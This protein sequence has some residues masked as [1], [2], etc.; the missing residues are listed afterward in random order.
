MKNDSLPQNRN[1]ARKKPHFNYQEIFEYLP[2]GVFTIDTQWKITSFNKTAEKITDY[3]RQEVIGRHCWEVFRSE[4]CS[5]GCPLS[6]CFETGRLQMDQEVAVTDRRG[7]TKNLIVNVNVLQDKDG[8]VHGGVETFRPPARCDHIPP[9]TAPAF[10][11]IIGKS[12]MMQ[13]IFGMLPDVAASET[14]VLL[15]GESG[16]GKEVLA[17]ALHNRSG[18]SRGPFVAVNCSALAESI[19]ESELFGHEKG[20][21]TGADSLKQ[22]RFEMARGGTLFLDEIGDLKPQIQVKL[23]RVLE[24][25]EFERVG[26]TRSIKLDARIISA[27]NQNLE[28]AMNEKRFRE[29]LYFRLRTVPFY[30]PPLRQRKEDIP[31]LVS[32]FIKIFNTRYNKQVRSVDPKVMRIF[33]N[34]N[35]PGNIRELE[36]ILEYAFVFVKGPVIFE[37]HLPEIKTAEKVQPPPAENRFS[38]GRSRDKDTILQ[39]LSDAGG[40]RQGAAELLGI[41]RTSL[42]RRMKEFGLA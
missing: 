32:H 16:T 26:G 3:R 11:G 17:R 25:R 1:T 20:A 8:N 33:M 42:W 19:L 21:F 31:P 18:R 6:I 37:R 22:G 4:L 10:E 14:N 12:S 35:W 38:T 39:A 5:K 15:C 29:D 13:S 9:K 36:R 27:T 2:E 28:A 23:L 40:N 24:E 7:V 30:I 41:S 34:H